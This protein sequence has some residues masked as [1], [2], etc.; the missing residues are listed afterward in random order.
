MT[1]TSAQRETVDAVVVG[2]GFA[3]LYSIYRLR[4]LGLDVIGFESAADVGGVWEWNRYPGARCDSPSLVY[5]YSFS[6]ELREEWTWTQRYPE[7]PEIRSYLRTAAERLGLYR[8]MRFS[9]RVVA[10]SWDE[11]SSRWAVTTHEGVTVLATYVVLAVGCLS[12]SQTP[13]FLGLD[14]FTGESFHTA[15]WPNPAP[16][17]SGKSV[18]VVGT[19]SSGTQVIPALAEAAESLYVFQRTANFVLPARNAPLDHA[20]VEEVNT[21]YDSLRDAIRRSATGMVLM[22]PV[23]RAVDLT[24][25]ERD[26]AMQERWDFGGNG[27]LSTFADTRSDPAANEMVSEFVRRKIKAIVHDPATADLLCPRIPLFEKRPQFGDG[28]YETFN[29]QNVT[30]VDS[31]RDELRFH[32]RGVSVGDRDIELD[33]L[34]LATGFDAM[35][36][37]ILRID[38]SGRGG[39][40]LRE[41]WANGPQTYLGLLSHGFPNLF[42]MAGPGSPSVLGNVPVAIEQH[43]EWMADLIASAMKLGVVSIEATADAEE[44]W[45][46]HVEEV[47]AQT[48]MAKGN[49]WYLGSNIPGKPRKFLPYA[50]GYGR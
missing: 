26:A 30:L 40:P 10:A 31:S 34:V 42:I 9:T 22:A 18:G 32:A 5:C 41:H 3:G 15:S 39:Y 7:A 24:E 33:C 25:Q 47:G 50:G 17:F 20:H 23:G 49:S 29:R 19:G 45:V 28:Y 16:D 38:I 21:N 8:H 1:Q 12:D 36:G 48:P 27:F 13:A 46:A 37:S 11:Q 6:K 43:V 2:A 14:K 35:T 44:R 4:Q